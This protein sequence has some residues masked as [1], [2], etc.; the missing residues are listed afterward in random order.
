MFKQTF[1][2][3]SHPQIWARKNLSEKIVI[4]S[5]NPFTDFIIASTSRRYN[6]FRP[7]RELSI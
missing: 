1:Y 5:T 3:S 7:K 2:F 4:S 6:K